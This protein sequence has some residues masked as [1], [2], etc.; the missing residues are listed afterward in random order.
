VFAFHFLSFYCGIFAV[1]GSAPLMEVM[2]AMPMVDAAAG[3]PISVSG[4]GVR[5][6]TFET[7]I[8]ALT[9]LPE[10]LAVSASLAGWLMSV[11]WGAL[12]GLLFI[13]GKSATTSPSLSSDA[14]LP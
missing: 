10:A 6:K 7:L 12:G 9:G 4:L 3:L 11:V 14:P 13:C 2:A 5:E 8:H 1:G